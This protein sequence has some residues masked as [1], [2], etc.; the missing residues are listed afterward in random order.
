[1]NA[2]PNWTLDNIQKLRAAFGQATTMPLAD[3]SNT[4]DD[5]EISYAGYV[6]A[7]YGLDIGDMPL[8]GNLGVRMVYTTSKMNAYLTSVDALGNISYTP[9]QTKSNDFNWTPSFNAKLAIRDDL[10]LRLAASKTVERPTF[11]QLNPGLYLSSG[12]ATFQNNGTAGNPDLSLVK[13]NN[14]DLG[15]GYYFAGRGAIT[16]TAFYRQIN[17]YVQY[18]SAPETHGG[19]TYQVTRPQNS[20]QGFLQG[21]ELA[22][23]QWYDNLPSLLS[24]FGLSANATFIEGHFRDIV[25]GQVEPYAGVS[26]WS[27]NVIPM[28]QHG[29]FS[30]RLSYDWRSS[31]QVGYTFADGTSVNPPTAYTKPYGELGLSVDYD[32]NDHVT[33][34]FDMNNVLD[35][36]YQDHFGSGTF[37]KYYPRDTRHYDQV[38]E[39][40][41]RYRM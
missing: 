28:Y 12:S 5:R 37:A 3:P 20:G 23:T 6:K 25:T 9:L 13:S 1:M 19:L 38:Y 7:D 24:G 15:L 16:G 30:M 14:V 35:S 34:T 40:G 26:R 41:L 22:Y 2:D 17:G 8:T 18:K 33:L 10:Q 39:F 27:F 21:F 32:W 4:F 31:Y 11:A 36:I 29:P